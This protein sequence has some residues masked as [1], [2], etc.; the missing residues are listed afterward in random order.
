MD[1][2]LITHAFEKLGPDRVARGMQAFRERAARPFFP[3]EIWEKCF[4]GRA[5]GLSHAALQACGAIDAALANA[6]LLTSWGVITDAFDSAVTRPTLEAWAREWLEL[7]RQPQ[8]AVSLMAA[9][10]AP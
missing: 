10:A 4:L 7:N 3:D 2:Q 9:Q 6:D 8:Q 5:L 1:K